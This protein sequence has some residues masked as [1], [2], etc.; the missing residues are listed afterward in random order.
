MLE[1]Q[2]WLDA[3]APSSFPAAVAAAAAERPSERG[4]ER[5]AEPGVQHRVHR[6]VP[7][8]QVRRD[9]H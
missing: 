1:Q 6:A 7:V 2:T 9:V 4:A 5:L 8:R 3:V